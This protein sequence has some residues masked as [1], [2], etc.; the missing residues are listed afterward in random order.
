MSDTVPRY[1]A[2]VI[3]LVAGTGEFI[4]NAQGEI[5]TIWF[6]A[7][8]PNTDS[9]TYRYQVRSI[10]PDSLRFSN[11][12]MTGERLEIIGRKV[13][14]FNKVIILDASVSNAIFDV[15]IYY[16]ASL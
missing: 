5:D 10:N 9:I 1:I 4:F 14:Q 11:T 2:G 12:D 7:R 16:A 15:I 6:K 8:S 3:S 13:Q